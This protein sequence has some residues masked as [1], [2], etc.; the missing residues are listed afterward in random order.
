MLPPRDE[1]AEDGP[2]APP[3]RALDDDDDEEPALESPRRR[4]RGPAGRMIG[5][6]MQRKTT[7]S[8][9]FRVQK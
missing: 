6:V 5:R 8:C 4:C 9:F 7:E 2:G 1:A 3:G